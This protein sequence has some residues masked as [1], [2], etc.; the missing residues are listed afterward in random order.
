[1]GGC[2]YGGSNCQHDQFAAN[3]TLKVMGQRLLENL[4]LCCEYELL[5]LVIVVIQVCW[6]ILLCCLHRFPF[7][8][9]LN[10]PRLDRLL[11]LWT[12][13]LKR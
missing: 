5:R 11:Q 7:I 8:F 10:M 12:F 2:I 9:L 1:M 6:C 3:S 4:E 13:F